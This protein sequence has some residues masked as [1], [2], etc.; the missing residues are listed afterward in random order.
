M[1]PFRMSGPLHFEAV[2]RS[3]SLADRFNTWGFDQN[4]PCVEW[5]APNMVEGFDSF[6]KLT[7]FPRRIYP[8]R[9]QLLFFYR[10]LN[11]LRSTLF[12]PTPNREGT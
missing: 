2:F 1:Q 11:R 7:F 5:H 3:Q 4:G 6:N 12:A 10:M 8:V 9:R